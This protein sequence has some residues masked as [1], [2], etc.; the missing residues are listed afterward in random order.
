MLP[1]L[2]SRHSRGK[3]NDKRL[4]IARRLAAEY[5]GEKKQPSSSTKQDAAD[6]QPSHSIL[7]ASS[8]LPTLQNTAGNPLDKS[9]LLQDGSYSNSQNHDS[10]AQMAKRSK[11]SSTK[12]MKNTDKVYNMALEKKMITDFNFLT[13]ET[14]LS[15]LLAKE[16]N[17]ISL[18]VDVLMKHLKTSLFGC[19][20]DIGIC[21][22]SSLKEIEYFG[23]SNYIRKVQR[24]NGI[25]SFTCIDRKTIVFEVIFISHNDDNGFVIFPFYVNIN[26]QLEDRRLEGPWLMCDKYCL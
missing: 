11:M 15:K 9:T 8:S 10:Q 12:H 13:L 19:D 2:N 18:I 14:E 16:N 20:F 1:S 22:D 24:K 3:N 6:L 21:T 4:D 26:R 25:T 7:S 23:D 5:L 17:K